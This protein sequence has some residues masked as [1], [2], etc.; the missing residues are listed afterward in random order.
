MQRL[1]EA[2]MLLRVYKEHDVARYVQKAVSTGCLERKE[3]MRAVTAVNVGQNLSYTFNEGEG[4]QEANAHQLLALLCHVFPY[5]QQLLHGPSNTAATA[6]VQEQ[7]PDV[8]IL[9]SKQQLTKVL[10]AADMRLAQLLK[11]A[12]E[13]RQ[14]KQSA[15][16][17]AASAEQQLNKVTQELESKQQEVETMTRNQDDKLTEMKQL[18]ERETAHRQVAQQQQNKMTLELESERTKCRKAQREAEDAKQS[19]EWAQNSAQHTLHTLMQRQQAQQ[20]VEAAA[21]DR[22]EQLAKSVQAAEGKA[23]RM[24]ELAMSHAEQ[25]EML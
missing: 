1:N 19:R 6:V 13:A 14:M 15:E 7:H 24:E 5:I 12:E 20:R 4:Q 2:V 17:Q 25:V 18:L 16:A 8:H 21:R 3:F 22:E 10:G 23:Q 9:V 11:E